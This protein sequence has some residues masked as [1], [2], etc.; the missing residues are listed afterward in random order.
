LF[1]P[2]TRA[3][4]LGIPLQFGLQGFGDVGRVYL[5]G[6]SSDKWHTGFG[7]GPY[8]SSPGRRNLFSI[9]VTRSEGRTSLY[10]RAGLG[11]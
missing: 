11:F 10:F 9:S 8:F 6:E 7:G 4:F 3:S 5:E 1:L 2:V